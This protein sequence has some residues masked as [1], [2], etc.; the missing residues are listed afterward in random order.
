MIERIRLIRNVGLFD[1]MDDGTRL[2][3][4]KLTLVYAEN[5]RGKTTLAAILRSLG[6]GAPLPITERHRLSAEYP[7]HVVMDPGSGAQPVTFQNGVWSQHLEETA[8]FDDAFIDQNVYSGLTVEADHR[9]NL[10]ELILG[11]QGIAL[12]NAL[13]EAVDRIEQHNRALKA[14]GD[15]IPVTVRGEMDADAFCAL[16][17]RPDIDA[18]IQ[19][20]ERNFAAAREQ[21]AIRTAIPFETIELPRFDTQA[22]AILL[23]RDLSALDEATA[24]KVRTHLEAVGPGGERWVSEGMRFLDELPSDRCP[25][26]AQDLNGSTLIEHYRAYFGAAYADLKTA[27][28][29]AL[30]NLERQ[31]GGDV[32][33]AFERAVRVLDRAPSILVAVLRRARNN[34]R[35]RS[36]SARSKRRQGYDACPPSAQARRTA[37][38][39][40]GRSRDGGCG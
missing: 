1:S 31:H 16:T 29:D 39:D 28:G 18:E 6:T 17:R 36:N 9:Q 26:C 24:R 15:A 12:N 37:R 14:K 25:F 8:V 19:A 30:R 7:P 33:A 4:S 22:L 40:F 20:A 23:A 5:G 2:P 38:K 35:H 11:S 3:F 10:H 13:Q 27:I 34:P 32:S 21:D